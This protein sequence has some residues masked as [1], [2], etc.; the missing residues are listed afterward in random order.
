[1]IESDTACLRWSLYTIGGNVPYTRGAGIGK[2]SE[3][4]PGLQIVLCN[5]GL[6]A[7]GHAAGYSSSFCPS[8]FVLCVMYETSDVVSTWATNITV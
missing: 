7:P 6:V 4:S 2:A 8:R 3:T 5:D 1:M